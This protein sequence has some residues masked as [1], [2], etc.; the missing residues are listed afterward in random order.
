MLVHC[1]A[2]LLNEQSNSEADPQSTL[3]HLHLLQQAHAGNAWRRSTTLGL[4]FPSTVS[5]SPPFKSMSASRDSKAATGS[6]VCRGHSYTEQWE[7]LYVWVTCQSTWFYTY[8]GIAK[9]IIGMWAKMGFLKSVQTHWIRRTTGEE[10]RRAD[11]SPG[12]RLQ[13]YC[14]LR[15]RPTNYG[16][17]IDQ[18]DSL[19]TITNMH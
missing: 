17:I 16:I 4:P 6:A 1:S 10:I 8:Q 13:R 9:D 18:N 12:Q 14:R 3:L 2:Q 15:E 11:C 19:Y 7:M 5:K